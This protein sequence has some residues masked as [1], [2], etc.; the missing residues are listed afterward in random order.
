MLYD[1]LLH[2][3]GHLQVVDSGAKSPRRRFAGERRAQEFAKEW[4]DKLWAHVFDHPDPV[5]NPPSLDE[6][7]AIG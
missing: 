6:L 7:L 5:H 2:E 1:A 3:I 4:R